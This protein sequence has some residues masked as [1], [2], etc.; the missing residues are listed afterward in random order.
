M[1]VGK[2]FLS[3]IGNLEV[4]VG[5]LNIFDYIK[6]LEFYVEKYVKK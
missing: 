6:N 5:K 1:G 2:N 4:L 3:K